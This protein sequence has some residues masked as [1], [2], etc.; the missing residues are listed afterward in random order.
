MEAEM[1]LQ[2]EQTHTTGIPAPFWI[3]VTSS[4]TQSEEYLIRVE[5][6]ERWQTV[7]QGVLVNQTGQ[8]LEHDAGHLTPKYTDMMCEL[9]RLGGDTE[10]EVTVT[11]EST[12]GVMQWSDS[13]F[14]S[15]T[16][17]EDE[18]FAMN[19]EMI[20]SSIAAVLFVAIL[21]TLLLRKRNTLSEH[22]DEVEYQEPEMQHAV[23]GPP[24][25]SNGPP[26]SQ[27][28]SPTVVNQSPVVENAVN[29][30]V[31]PQLPPDGLPAGWTMEQ[32]Q[33]YG[34]QYLDTKQ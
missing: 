10:G 25:S 17:V 23:I 19:S 20:A 33:Y 15:F 14:F 7:C 22:D 28:S 34:Q 5:Q 31:G 16:I 30:H 1:S 4:S 18:G 13:R 9:H 26:A 2:S 11:I 21:L 12:D 27:V 6:P 8:V 24:V 29:S 32:W 3:N